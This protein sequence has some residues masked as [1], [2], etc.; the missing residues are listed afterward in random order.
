MCV[1]VRLSLQ[2]V[3][4]QL[5]PVSPSLGLRDQVALAKAP[6]R[7]KFGASDHGGGTMVIPLPR[8]LGWCW[9]M[10]HSCDVGWCWL[11]LARHGRWVTCSILRRWFTRPGNHPMGRR[12]TCRLRLHRRPRPQVRKSVMM[13]QG[14]WAQ[15][16]GLLLITSDYK[17]VGLTTLVVMMVSLRM[18]DS[19]GFNQ[20]GE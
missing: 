4:V 5:S 18:V 9:F 7:M 15:T 19:G 11:P 10:G 3:A 12:R 13:I 17:A 8:L 16:Y 20:Q 2:G 6:G 1:C 14:L